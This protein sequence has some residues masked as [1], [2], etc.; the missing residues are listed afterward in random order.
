M[1]PSG[2]TVDQWGARR[3]ISK[4]AAGLSEAA[5]AVMFDTSESTVRR[6]LRAA[7]NTGAPR[8]PAP[9][10]HKDDDRWHFAMSTPRGL[11]NLVWL[12]ACR[13]LGQDDELLRKTYARFLGG[14]CIGEPSFSSMKD[15]LHNQLFFG[16]KRLTAYAAERDGEACD[17]WAGRFHG[18]Y[19]ADQIVC[20]D[21]TGSDDKVQNRRKGIARR[22]KR[23]RSNRNTFHKGKR[24]SAMSGFTVLDGFLEPFIV[25]GTFNK[26]RFLTG[27]RRCVLPY[28]GPYP[29]PRSVLL[30]DNC[31]VHPSDEL[32]EM[33]YSIGARIEWLEPYDPQHMPIEL[34]FRAYKD[35]RR[36]NRDLFEALTPR[37]AV[38]FGL[39]RVSVRSARNAFAESG[40]DVNDM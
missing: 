26:R 17:R 34:G 4:R 23:A 2:E 22:G 10:S 12:D 19:F 5:I 24:F 37:E 1:P 6:I 9:G 27:I 7:R 31:K 39:M 15:A 20:V 36:N 18:T 29:G 3:I 33:V 25:E 11:A 38:R 21:E 14:P 8:E 35:D 13:E 32:V 16:T 30:L 28:M 40:F